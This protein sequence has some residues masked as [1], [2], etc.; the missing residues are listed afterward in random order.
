MKSKIKEEVALIA[1]IALIL[2]TAVMLTT[3]GFWWAIPGIKVFAAW[4]LGIVVTAGV[5][6]AI[7]LYD[8][9]E[10]AKRGGRN[11]RR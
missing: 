6:V 11:G 5:C 4:M 7:S 10:K 8:E 1:G 9:A 3:V 2:P